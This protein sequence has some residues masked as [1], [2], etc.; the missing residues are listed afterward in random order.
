MQTQHHR[1]TDPQDHG[2]VEVGRDLRSKPC[3]SRDTYSTDGLGVSQ[4][5]SD[6]SVDKQT[7]LNIVK[8]GLGAERH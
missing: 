7:K 4:A 8:E 5:S 3:P 2:K 6:A 1:I